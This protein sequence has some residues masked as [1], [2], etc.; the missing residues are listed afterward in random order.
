MTITVHIRRVT[1]WKTMRGSIFI[2]ESREPEYPGGFAPFVLRTFSPWAASLC[3]VAREQQSPVT[4]EIEAAKDARFGY[5][6]KDVKA[7]VA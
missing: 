3:Q 4:L 2:V 1:E 5:R 7:R 6:I